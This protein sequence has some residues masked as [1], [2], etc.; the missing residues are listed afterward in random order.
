[1]T[2]NSA[3]TGDYSTVHDIVSDPKVLGEQI[4][5]NLEGTFLENALFRNAGETSSLV[6]QYR[7]AASPYLKDDAEN[8]AEFAEIPVSDT[9]LGELKTAVAIKT[10]LGIDISREMVK[11]NAMDALQRKVSAL[12]NSM[13][14]NSVSATLSAINNAPIQTLA[15]SAE[16]ENP[17]SR[18]L[19]D[20]LM[21]KRSVSN[22]SNENDPSAKFGYSADTL[23]LS[24]SAL[25][26]L[27]MH[28]Q[29][30]G[31]FVG[32][33]A[34]ENPL[35]KGIQSTSIGGL[36]IVTSNLLP[37]DS[38]YVL[39][40]GTAGFISD[41]DPLTVTDLYSPYGDN[42]FGG[43]R[44]VFRVDAFRNRIMAVDAPK[45]IVKLEGIVA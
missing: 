41:F 14:R 15:V 45:S 5:S 38:V 4:Y 42:G 12:Q 2:L 8:V 16:W 24:E 17:E 34:G 6:A 11:S 40:S 39:E 26:M 18:P 35:Y 19:R 23:L 31:L 13:V 37:E 9:D 32:N 33:I 36:Q 43:T 44:Q 27:E 25:T 20:I 29:F 21:G 30:Q 1:M 3:Y 28:D 10:A 7:E 22:A